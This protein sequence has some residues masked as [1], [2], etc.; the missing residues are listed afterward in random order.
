MGKGERLGNA[1]AGDGNLDSGCPFCR[2][3]TAGEIRIEYGSALAFED[4][5]PVTPG[6]YLVIPASHA[7]DFFELSDKERRDIEQLLLL[8]SREILLKDKNVTGFNIGWNCGASAGQTIFHAHCHLIPRR[9]GDHPN[10]RGGV[11]GVIP[12][13]MSY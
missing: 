13:R 10:P 8:L 2:R 1:P 9:D 12:G 11:R 5:N 3:I 4:S 7:N 6:H